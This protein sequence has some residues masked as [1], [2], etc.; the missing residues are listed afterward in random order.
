MSITL[1]P[2]EPTRSDSD[3]PP[4]ST[5]GCAWSYGRFD[6]AIA[7]VSG[8]L[9]ISTTPRLEQTL[10]ACL[11]QARR[12]VLD[13]HEV[14]FI[15]SSGVHAIVDASVR[16]RQEGRRLVLVRV[17]S[18]VLRVFTLSERLHEVE[19]GADPG[20]LAL[21]TP[22][23]PRIRGNHVKS[24]ETRLRAVADPVS[25]EHEPYD[26]LVRA[27]VDTGSAGEHEPATAVPEDRGP[28]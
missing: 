5:F 17:P 14:D 27:I 18:H 2:P 8:E 6:S 7:R 16:A 10:R 20:E 4:A 3:P 12:V 15:D 11:L 9:D 28:R 26:R 13:L 1:V 22:V 23:Q 25:I 24:G 19:I 21:E